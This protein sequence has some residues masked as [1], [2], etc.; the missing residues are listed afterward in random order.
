MKSL[1][2]RHSD[3]ID[4]KNEEIERSHAGAQM[5][6]GTTRLA[7]I[8]IDNGD[9]SDREAGEGGE[10]GSGGA[11]RSAAIGDPGVGFPAPFAAMSA[12]AASGSG[13]DPRP[14]TAGETVTENGKRAKTGGKTAAGAGGGDW[15]PPAN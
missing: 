13:V 15:N 2:E 14:G 4:R 7:D 12:L 3:R 10:E 8:G 6:G 9:G 11:V 5:L 1:A